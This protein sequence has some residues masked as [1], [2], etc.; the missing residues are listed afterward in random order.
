MTQD[1]KKIFCQRARQRTKNIT[2]TFGKLLF[3]TQCWM[4]YRIY[5]PPDK[6]DFAINLVVIADGA[7][8]KPNNVRTSKQL[9]FVA[10][11]ETFNGNQA[12]GS[13]LMNH[14]HLLMR[15]HSTSPALEQ[16][17]MSCKYNVYKKC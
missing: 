14:K 3:L 5:I 1:T 9:R 16:H 2:T 12:L 15:R 7:G 17:A 6:K 4:R 13:P 8:K 10:S 11:T